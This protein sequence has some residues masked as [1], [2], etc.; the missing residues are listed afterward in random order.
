VPGPLSGVV[1]KVVSLGNKLITQSVERG[2]LPQLYAATAPDVQGGEY[3]GP[4][5][6]GEVF[7]APDRAKPRAAA[8]NPDLGRTLWQ[9]TAELTGVSPDPE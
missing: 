8:V 6:P 9:R 4:G 3:F 7:G 1:S 2:A 5:G